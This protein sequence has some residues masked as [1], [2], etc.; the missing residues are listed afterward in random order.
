MPPQGAPW[1]VE[2]DNPA[3]VSA[4]AAAIRAGVEAADG[5]AWLVACAPDG[6]VG[7]AVAAV[8]GGGARSIGALY[9][10]RRGIGVGSALLRGALDVHAGHDVRLEVVAGDERA[11]RFY[12]RHGFEFTGDSPAGMFTQVLDRPLPLRRMIRPAGSRTAWRR[13]APRGMIRA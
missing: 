8:D 2:G 13:P 10:S 7:F 1:L 6:V 12:M 4:R 5:G 3:R 9:V 11:A